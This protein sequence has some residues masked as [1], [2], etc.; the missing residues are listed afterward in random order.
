M[1][2]TIPK[3]PHY[4]YSIWQF[5]LSLLAA[6]GLVAG[7]GL[8]IVFGLITYFG[9]FFTIPVAP[10]D[11]GVMIF[12][13]GGGLTACALLVIPSVIYPIRRISGKPI[14]HYPRYPMI[15]RPTL[16]ILVWPLILLLG[17]WV[18]QSSSLAWLLLPVLHV[19]A[20]GLPVLWIVYLA[21]RGLPLGSP[22]RLSGVVASGVVLGPSI[23]MILEIGAL[24]VFGIIGFLI[25]LSHPDWINQLSDL[26]SSFQ[27]GGFSEQE[28][29]EALLPWLARPQILIGVLFFVALI[30][31]MIEE[32]LK[33]IGVWLL[34]GFKLSPAAGFAAG[35]I[36]GAG[37]AFFESLGLAGSGVDWTASVAA[38]LGTAIIH[39]VNA[40]LMG[41]ALTLAWREKRYLNL[42]L[43]YLLVVLV[44]GSWNALAVLNIYSTTLLNHSGVSLNPG[45]VWLGSAA[46]YLLAGSALVMFA[47]LLKMNSKLRRETALQSAQEGVTIVDPGQDGEPI[48]V[49]L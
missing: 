25:L 41:W 16:L 37:F 19:L 26:L 17:Y 43:T 22:Q 27:N 28:L 3:P 13:L 47:V 4:T 8:S 35:A 1:N 39:I 21:G 38:R 18:S 32:A 20:I 23:I 49:V 33:P 34:A 31:P 30:V 7:A 14:S 9:S 2:S 12:L 24:L 42:G 11:Q 5:I 46:P 36:C 6:L 45:L 40:G 29:L 15:L 44:H 48:E 10:P